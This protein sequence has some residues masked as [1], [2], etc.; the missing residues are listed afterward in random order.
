MASKWAICQVLR[1]RQAVL[2]IGAL[3]GAFHSFPCGSPQAQPLATAALAPTATLPSM[4]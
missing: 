1:F 2:L 4:A 3:A